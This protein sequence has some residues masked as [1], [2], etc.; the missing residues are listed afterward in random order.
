MS[1]GQ[2]YVARHGDRAI[3]AVRL[4]DG[5]IE[6][7]GHA[8]PFTVERD[9]DGDYL[10][11]DG[12]RHWRVAVAGPVGAR[13]VAVAG[14]HAMLDIEAEGD[15][16][17]PVRKTRH[18]EAVAP[19]PATVVGI[20]VVPDQHVEP[21]DIVLKLEAMKMELPVR[22]P[23]AGTVRTIRCQVGDLVQPGTVL[24]DIT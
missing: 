8:G 10:V 18:G 2:R 1:D 3:A 22:A 19:M 7:E 20:L 9:R 17:R 21:G 11:S 6:V 16:R 23:R 24:V 12:A 15:T 13:L 5:R 14:T 4:A